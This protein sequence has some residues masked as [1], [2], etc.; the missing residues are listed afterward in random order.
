MLTVAM[1]EKV[2]V[3]KAT[4]AASPVRSAFLQLI[5]SSAGHVMQIV[6]VLV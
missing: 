2:G 6:V 1:A 5:I 4:V 3:V